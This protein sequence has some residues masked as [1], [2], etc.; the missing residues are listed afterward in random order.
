LNSGKGSQQHIKPAI[1]LKKLYELLA[2]KERFQVAMLFMGSLVTAFA[3]AIGVF[4]V[5]PFI[6]VVMNPDMIMQNRWLLLVYERGNFSEPY[7]FIRFMGVGVFLAVL[8]SSFMSALIMWAKTKFVMG[9]NHSLSYRLLQKYLSKPYSFFLMKNSSELAK[10]ILAEIKQL[11]EQLLMAVFEIMINSLMLVFIVGML[12]MV[13]LAVTVG[14]MLFLGGTYFLVN[15]YLKSRLKKKGVQRFEANNERFKMAN[16]ALSS[17]KVT[18]VMGVEDYFLNRYGVSSRRFARFNIYAKVAGHIPYYLIETIVFGGIVFFIILMLSRGDGITQIIPLVSLFAF[19]GKRILPA[20]QHLYIS[21]SQIY[22]NQPILDKIHEDMVDQDAGQIKS[23]NASIREKLSNKID[24]LPLN[25]RIILNGIRFGYDSSDAD[26][27]KHINLTIPKNNMIGF[28]GAT[29]SGKT[30]L[31]DIIM[32]LLEPQEGELLVDHTPITREN[33]RSWQNK[34]GYV[35]QE[36]Y[37]SD[38][39]IRNNIAFGVVDKEINDGQVQFAAKLA[40]L[41]EFILRNLPLQYET[42]IGE[43]GV[44]LSGGQ[45]QRIG[46]ARALYRNPEV[47]V[48]DEATSSLDGTTEENILQAIKSASETR[49]VIMIA[50]RLNTLKECDQIYLL[51]EG[52]IV[53]QGTYDT[54]METNHRFQSMAKVAR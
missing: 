40:S 9:K 39:S 3:Q 20:I 4:S 11:T 43:R 14:S 41:D 2:P 52:E 6:N 45:R 12:I 1:M 53:G 33:I 24:E 21:V 23:S 7:T 36:I 19:A 5:F 27:I 54:L 47:L 16:E 44:R 32:G 34:I 49:T 42:V 25:D 46:L 30:T 13:N 22:F 26:V 37:L 28:A 10:N 50:H 35:P 8:F 18:K 38:D 51:E 15:R 17:I 31:V 29:G 48:L